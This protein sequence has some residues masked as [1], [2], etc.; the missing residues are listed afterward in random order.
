MCLRNQ[1]VGRVVLP[2]DLPAGGELDTDDVSIPVV[3][4]PGA[5]K[6][7][8]T[9]LLVRA[10]LHL[11]QPSRRVIVVV[12]PLGQPLAEQP[13]LPGAPV[14]AVILIAYHSAQTVAHPHQPVLLVIPKGQR[15]DAASGTLSVLEGQE[16]FLLR[17]VAVGIVDILGQP[18]LDRPILRP[19]HRLPLLQQPSRPVVGIQCPD[20]GLVGFPGQIALCGDLLDHQAPQIVDIAFLYDP[21]RADNFLQTAR[22]VVAVDIARAVIRFSV[23]LFWLDDLHQIA[24]SVIFQ[25]PD[26]AVRVDDLDP[27]VVGV[28]LVPDALTAPGGRII[29]V[30]VDLHSQAPRSIIGSGKHIPQRVGGADTVIHGVILIAIAG[31]VSRLFIVLVG[32]YLGDQITQEVIAVTGGV[33][34]GIDLQRPGPQLGIAEL[35]LA[36]VALDGHTLLNL[37]IAVLEHRSLRRDKPGHPAAALPVFILGH[38][39]VSVR[40][41]D[42]AAQPVI[43][44][45]LHPA[46][47]GVDHL[48]LADTVVALIELG[49]KLLAIVVPP[50]DLVAPVI[51]LEL[52]NQAAG[53]LLAHQFPVLP[54]GPAGD[55]AAAVLLQNAVAPL[56]VLKLLIGTVIVLCLYRLLLVVVMVNCAATALQIV[57]GCL[58]SG[59]VVKEYM[60][61]AIRQILTDHAPLFIITV[62][63]IVYAI[64]VG[65]RNNQAPGI[66]LVTHGPTVG[67]RHRRQKVPVVLILDRT[68]RTVC[69][70]GN[71]AR[72]IGKVQILAAGEGQALNGSAAI[73]DLRPVPM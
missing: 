11:D 4:I 33:A 12:Y 42:H 70:F 71:L 26:A 41:G 52:P 43:L 19:G 67:V 38:I 36:G 34:Q 16:A 68:P 60:L 15:V 40:H 18:V 5:G 6:L 47:H 63:E 46:A 29:G 48:L 14:Q 10:L 24:H 69:D 65:D 35:D 72:L 57:I 13:S 22:R 23:I 54:V 51:I 55:L 7:A 21:V 53:Q 73:A 1:A 50:V 49:E 17:P 39:A 59:I 3:F 31:P 25:P 66:I 37:V 28:V 30:W 8:P 56:V 2:Q 64:L 61:F 27:P 9:P 62:D 44:V 45:G 58:A 32:Q 20:P